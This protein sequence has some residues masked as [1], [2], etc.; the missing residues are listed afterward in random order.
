MK[1]KH[2]VVKK[3]LSS[4]QVLKTLKVLMEDDYTM[5]ELIQKLNENEPEPIFNNSVISKYI[6]TCRFCGIVIPQIQNKYMVCKIPFG[7]NISDEEYSVLQ[8]MQNYADTYLSK[9]SR[10][11]F[12][13]FI[14]KVN[15]YSNREIVR[16]EDNSVNLVCSVFEKAI[17]TERKIKLLFRSG[18]ILFGIPLGFAEHKG[19]RCLSILCDNREHTVMLDRISGIELTKEKFQKANLDG[20]V[21]F[22]LTGALASNYSLRANETLIMNNKPDYITVENN[23]ENNLALVNRLLRYGE[24]C[25][26]ESPKNIRDEIKRN[27]NETL[28]NYGVV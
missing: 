25:E 20:D 9:R 3:N 21:L 2:E 4:T 23:G 28:A 18:K 22:K 7:M 26:I 6:S 12:D 14:N 5:A 8:D 11:Q 16:V 27:I 15:V 10:V 19:K 13:R 24:L 1:N 17:E